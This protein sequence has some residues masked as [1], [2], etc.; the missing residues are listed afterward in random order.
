MTL[1]VVTGAGGFIGGEISNYLKSKFQVY[2]AK[3]PEFDV[4]NLKT[5]SQLPP[6]ADVVIHCAARLSYE[7]EDKIKPEKVRKESFNVNVEGTMNVLRYGLVSHIKHFIYI[8][9]QAVYGAIRSP[10]EEAVPRPNS[11]YAISKYIGE[12]CSNWM[13]QQNNI[14]LT[15]LRLP[16]MFGP[17]Q[18]RFLIHHIINAIKEGKPITIYG[19]GTG[20]MDCFYIKDLLPLFERIIENNVTGLYNIGS[21]RQYSVNDIVKTALKIFGKTK[22]ERDYTKSGNQNNVLMDNTRARLQ[23]GLKI[24]YPLKVAFEDMQKGSGKGVG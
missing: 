14:K 6:R 7:S 20:K 23:L 24:K 15:I 9:T 2:P 19:Q 8:S 5:F 18:K 13:C 11:W 22:V 21:G 10:N 12:L 1:I 16:S 3:Y 17:T 4:T